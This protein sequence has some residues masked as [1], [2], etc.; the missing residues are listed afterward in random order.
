MKRLVL[1]GY[2]RR[3]LTGVGLALVRH[4]VAATAGQCGPLTRRRTRNHRIS[5]GVSE[6]KLARKLLG[7]IHGVTQAQSRRRRLVTQ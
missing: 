5:T 7:R 4:S 1:N 2:S 3:T 6:A